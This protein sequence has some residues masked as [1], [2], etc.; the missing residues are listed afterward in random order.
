VCS[1][2]RGD[3]PLA[4][5]GPVNGGQRNLQSPEL[6]LQ[7]VDRLSALRQ[8]TRSTALLDMPDGLCGGLGTEIDDGTLEPMRHPG[9]LRRIAGA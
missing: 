3:H 7:G 9:E 8:V 1:L 4:V 6:S 5:T 2:T